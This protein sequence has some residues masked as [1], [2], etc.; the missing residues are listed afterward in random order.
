MI[1]RAAPIAPSGCRIAV[2]LKAPFASPAVDQPA[3]PPAERLVDRG[4]GLLAL[5]QAH[6]ERVGVRRGGGALA[7]G[8][9]HEGGSIGVP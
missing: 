5:E 8:G 7:E 9:A 6:A 4:R 1:T 2:F 3:E